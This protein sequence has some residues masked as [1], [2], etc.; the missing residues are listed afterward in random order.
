MCG[1]AYLSAW[2]RHGMHGMA[3]DMSVHYVNAW[4][5]SVILPHLFPF[6][7][8]SFPSLLHIYTHTHTHTHT[9]D[10]TQSG[11]TALHDAVNQEHEDVVDLLLEAHIDPDVPDKVSHVTSTVPNM[12]YHSTVHCT[13]HVPTDWL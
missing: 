13:E 1:E 3:V 4:V 7:L 10:Y 5:I 11:E 2:A 12:K 6:P 9:H 8:H